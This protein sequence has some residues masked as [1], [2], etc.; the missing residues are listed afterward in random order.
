MNEQWVLWKPIT[1]C[2][3]HYGIAKML[4]DKPQLNIVLYPWEENI[5][6][7][8]I[9]FNNIINYSFAD[10]VYALDMLHYQ[11]YSK[12]FLGSSR[13]FKVLNSS[14]V[15]N[16]FEQYH[17]SGQVD[18][19]HFVINTVDG[20]IDI[21]SSEEPIVVETDPILEKNRSKDEL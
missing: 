17:M 6:E 4:Y 12:E 1:Q 14:Y 21:V 8:S 10:D 16:L 5:K 13:F 3:A 18:Y 11:E 7:V 9:I 20:T 2:K 15:Q 19:T